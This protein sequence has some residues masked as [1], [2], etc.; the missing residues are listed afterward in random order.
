MDLRIG[1]SNVARELSIELDE[2]TDREAL[3]DDI[4]TALMGAGVLW[5]TDRHGKK[6]GVPVDKVAYV[7]LGTGDSRRVGFATT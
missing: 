6:V 5:I 7:E 2:S 4:E 3:R 1:V